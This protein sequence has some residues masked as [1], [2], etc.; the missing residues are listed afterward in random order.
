MSPA[1]AKST[2]AAKKVT[3]LMKLLAGA[4]EVGEHHRRQRA[5]DAVAD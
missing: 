3:A 2:N 5:A 1:S 4:R